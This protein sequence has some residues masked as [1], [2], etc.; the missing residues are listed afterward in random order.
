[1]KKVGMVRW[2]AAAVGAIVVCVSASSASCPSEF[3]AG[4][5]FDVGDNRGICVAA[6]LNGD[7]DLDLT[8]G[9]FA[10][11]GDGRGRFGAPFP[12]IVTS[13]VYD[14]TVEDFDRDGHADVALA[15]LGA[16]AVDVLFGR[17]K[18]F[19]GDDLFEPAVSVPT[20]HGSWHIACGDLDG[21]GTLDMV[22][23]SGQEPS[24]SLLL[25]NG[26]RTFESLRLDGMPQGTQALALGDYDGDGRLDIAT[27]YGSNAVLL[28]GN[29]D[30]TFG[31]MVV[32]PLL[33]A[34]TPAEVHR[35]RAVDF[36]RDGR[37]DLV[38]CTGPGVSVY[39]GAQ[40]DRGAGLPAEAAVEIA[41][42][43]Y[44]RYVE[45]ADLNHDGF[46]DIVA[47]SGTEA[48]DTVF[49]VL[50]G[51]TPAPDAPV[52]FTVGDA[53]SPTL[54]GRKPVFTLGDMDGDGAVDV[55]VVIEPDGVSQIL[56]GTEGSALTAPGDANRNGTINVADA[57]VILSHL[58]AHVQ[59]PCPNVIEVNG[60]GRVDLADAI[61]VLSY[62]FAHGPMPA[63]T[64]R[65]CRAR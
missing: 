22:A 10:V 6:D 57:I 29:G 26:D 50:C 65:A 61:Y 53:F 11:L 49:R 32:S 35:L 5:L 9:W 31:G 44:G 56:F 15:Y 30:G 48:K 58:F 7:G 54:S 55:V 64:P 19:E 1:M 45:L 62:L 41:L 16:W 4:E 63:G 21:N 42:D 17:E 24:L 20:V 2:C 8:T 13:P 23:G 39:R 33:F 60:D 12:L 47:Q 46:L 59:A 51:R 34:G 25:N 38:A 14:V 37:A 36:D 28:F 3:S 43:G 52:A 27:G 18:E 40:I